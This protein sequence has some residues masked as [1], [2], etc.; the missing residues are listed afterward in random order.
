MLQKQNRPESHWLGPQSS[1][2]WGCVSMVG[3]LGLPESHRLGPQS[4][5][6]RGCVS[7]VGWLGLHMRD[8]GCGGLCL[9]LPSGRENVL[10]CALALKT[11][12]QMS[13]LLTFHWSKQVTWKHPTPWGQGGAILLCVCVWWLHP[14][15]GT[16]TICQWWMR[17]KYLLIENLEG[18]NNLKKQ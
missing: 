18:R 5:L 11:S 9:Q 8:P 7:M 14:E 4:S 15:K 6:P 13:A 1:L 16:T 10:K 12:A 3:W 17:E 2:P